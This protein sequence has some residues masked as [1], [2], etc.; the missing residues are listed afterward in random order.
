MLSSAGARLYSPH[1]P[2]AQYTTPGA[3]A[4]AR[5]APALGAP[6][7]PPRIVGGATLSL[8]EAALG[9]DLLHIAPEI[10]GKR[11]PH[12][13]RRRFVPVPGSH[14]ELVPELVVKL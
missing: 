1:T 9:L 7:R 4:S 10:L 6:R 3:P 2:P 11:A 13:L 14:R 12:R 8:G 5:M